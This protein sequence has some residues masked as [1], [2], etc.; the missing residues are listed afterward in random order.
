MRRRPAKN[1]KFIHFFIY[2]FLICSG[3]FGIGK[4]EEPQRTVMN[5]EWLLC[6]TN[7]DSSTLP[8][9][10][11]AVGEVITRSLV[12]T[13]KVVNYRIRISP[14]YAYYEGYAQSQARSTAA[15]ALSAKHEERALTLY[16]GE[17][18]W[19]YKQ[20]I[21][22]IDADIVKLREELAKVEAEIPLINQEPVFAL[23][24][25]NKDGIFPESPQAGRERGFCMSQHA[26]AFLAGTIQEYHGRFR[27][28]L[29]LYTLYTGAFSY[30][31]EII[32]SADDLTVGVDEIAGRLIAVLAGS[33]PA[34]V[35]IHADPPESLV[36]INRSFAGRG[37]VEVH[38]RPPGKMEIALSAEDY[39]PEIV[40][41]TL[42]PG[43]LTDISV[44][45]LP[46]EYGEVNI[47]TPGETG[48]SVYQGSL[49]VG[50]AP[51]TLRLPLNQFENITVETAAG[52]IARAAFVS[53]NQSGTPYR[54]SMQL[55]TP[56]PG[57][58]RVNKA[59]KTY[60]WAWGG[61][62]LTTIAAWV[63]TGVLQSQ[64][65]AILGHFNATGTYNQDFYDTAQ[66]MHDV[67]TYAWAAV[68][69]ATAYEIFQMARYIY[70]STEDTTPILNPDK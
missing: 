57:Q 27:V 6:V 54:F 22:R 28:T 43:E 23:T 31:D 9:N 65:E 51:L 61:T 3:L 29:R 30:K 14:E 69:V 13:L 67:Y 38:E 63:L 32:F 58:D 15:K 55:K 12:D 21:K 33:K 20:N 62:W 2:F 17:N 53:P 26:D 34:A 25:S 10:R 19:R 66:R 16:R 56:P 48:A 1:R 4:K 59:R 46:M 52:E 60:Y 8:E 64:N 70:I 44:K 35:A 42:V 24:Q 11:Q 47:L 45:L 50:E 40:E 36:L 5:N 37:T 7:F 39:K 41:T 68:G 18:N 49:Y